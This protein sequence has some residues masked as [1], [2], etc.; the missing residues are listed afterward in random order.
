MMRLTKEQ[1]ESIVTNLIDGCSNV[2]GAMFLTREGMPFDGELP[3]RLSSELTSAISASIT[4]LTEDASE[5]LKLGALNQVILKASVGDAILRIVNEDIIL[6]VFISRGGLLG[7]ALHYIN[8][9]L[10]T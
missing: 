1:M 6:A 10:N 9:Q 2:A 4:Q 8:H 7:E 3:G 5:Q